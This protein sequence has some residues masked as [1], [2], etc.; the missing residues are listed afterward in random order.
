MEAVREIQKKY[1]S[2]AMIT[3]ILVAIALILAGQKG[4]GKGLVLGTLFSVF[5]FILMGETLPM[6]IGKPKGVTYMVTFGS[7]VIR[8]VLMAVPLVMAIKMDGINIFAAILGIF[9][10]QL[11]ILADHF[12]R[13][14]KPSQG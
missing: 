4:I 13:F 3:A 12:Y 1:C 7:I 6:R 14:V 11:I 10:V 8:Y 9:M 5:N 2:R